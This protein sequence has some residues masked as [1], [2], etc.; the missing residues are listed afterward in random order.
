M[1]PMV[2]MFNRSFD[3]D[4]P[5]ECDDEYW[6]QSDPSLNFVQPE[7]KPSVVAFFNSFLRLNQIQAFAIRTLACI[8]IPTDMFEVT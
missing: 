8:P 6:V 3:L 7:G 4:L 2:L 5:I 1:R